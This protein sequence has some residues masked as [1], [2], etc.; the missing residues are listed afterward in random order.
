MIND[1]MSILA[2]YPGYFSH[3]VSLWNCEM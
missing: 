2:W 3:K 1:Y